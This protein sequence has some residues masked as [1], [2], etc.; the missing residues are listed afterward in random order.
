MI[1]VENFREK[2]SYVNNPVIKFGGAFDFMDEVEET[3]FR[4]EQEKLE[5]KAEC[6]QKGNGVKTSFWGPEKTAKKSA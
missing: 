2:R 3:G 4:S 5:S 6:I 1:C